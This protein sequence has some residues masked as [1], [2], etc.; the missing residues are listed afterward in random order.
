MATMN[1]VVAPATQDTPEPAT[2]E[3]QAAATAPSS[4]PA[5]S[6]RDS[7]GAPARYQDHFFAVLQDL[8]ASGSVDSK[9]PSRLFGYRPDVMARF[10]TLSR[11]LDDGGNP[12]LYQQASLAAQLWKT[13]PSTGSTVSAV[14]DDIEFATSRNS[15]IYTVMNGL[16][17][18]VLWL[19]LGTLAFLTLSSFVY[20]WVS[21]ELW[22][23]VIS[24][25]YDYLLT[26]PV[27]VAS[28]FGMLGAVVSVLLRLS[29]FENAQRR[30][31]QFLRM[32]G[33]VLPLVGVVFA[34]VTCALF[35]SNLIN[36]SFAV[37]SA[38]SA[39][40]SAHSPVLHTNTYFFIV[41]GFLS[42]FSERFTRG[43]L[44]SAEQSLMTSRSEAQMTLRTDDGATLSKVT[45]TTNVMK[46]QTPTA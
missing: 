36:F 24:R 9:K 38:H 33:V 23:D 6:S 32:T 43:L 42:G 5:E 35:A 13:H 14:L 12:V 11:R 25:L 15:P 3:A 28:M 7:A 1:G 22:R 17:A 4:P 30:S 21:S 18:S 31:R 34:S 10:L 39:V 37:G 26:S 20:A 40:G 2:A 16:I 29:E 8:V 46:Q 19:S 41:I 44:G 45:Q 27:V